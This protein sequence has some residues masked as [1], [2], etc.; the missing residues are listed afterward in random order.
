M[1]LI[2]RELILEFINALY[3]N[4]RSRPGGSKLRFE[5]LTHAKR[6]PGVNGFRKF[7]APAHPAPIALWS[8]HSHEVSRIPRQRQLNP[9]QAILIGREQTTNGHRPCVILF[10]LLRKTIDLGSS[11]KIE[12]RR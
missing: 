2:K 8:F 6:R 4:V 11:S 1:R 9:T 5:L 7:S 3:V 10:V 12:R